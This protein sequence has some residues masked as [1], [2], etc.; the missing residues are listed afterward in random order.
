ME[1]GK[2]GVRGMRDEKNGGR[3]EIEKEGTQHFECILT[4]FWGLF[5][6]SSKGYPLHQI[7]PSLL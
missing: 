3:G 4:R 1:G 5:D 7:C 2:D 6:G